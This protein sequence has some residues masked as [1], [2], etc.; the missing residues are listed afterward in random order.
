MLSAITTFGCIMGRNYRGPTGALGNL[1][2]VALA[3]STMGKDMPRQMGKMLLE[4]V[5]RGMAIGADTMASEAGMQREMQEQ[6]EIVWYLDE[7]GGML[8]DWHATA[9]PSY[10][11][12]IRDLWLKTSNGERYSGKSLKDAK[13]QIV[14]ENPYPCI[15]ATAQPDMFWPYA[16]KEMISSG[17]L[18]RCLVFEGQILEKAQYGRKILTRE[19]SMPKLLTEQIIAAAKQTRKTGAVLT[20]TLATIH[21]PLADKD[22]EAA[23]AEV[24]DFCEDARYLRYHGEKTE[25]I[26]AGR[27]W[28][29]MHKLALVHAWSADPCNPKI[30]AESIHWAWRLVQMSN[31]VVTR[32]LRDSGGTSDF[33]KKYNSVLKHIARAQNEGIL[34][35]VLLNRCKFE[36]AKFDDIINQLVSGGRIRRAAAATGATRLYIIS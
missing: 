17:F 33:E 3:D 25:A 31:G 14:I 6:P 12:A 13:E 18:G 1:Y 7:L 28:E 35:S 8:R 2:T 26:L 32:G 36:Q 34:R 30:T 4:K 29:R 20:N 21:V 22:A 23:D 15:Y 19:E 11:L 5:G 16:D 27:S 9:C 24:H 10:K